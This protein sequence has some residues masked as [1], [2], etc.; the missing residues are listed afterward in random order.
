MTD[1]QLARE[2][3]VRIA[4]EARL[5]VASVVRVLTGTPCAF[6]TT[7]QET[8]IRALA[9]QAVARLAPSRRVRRAD[10]RERGFGAT[11]DALDGGG[12]L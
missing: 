3:L 5:D 8:R 4:R 2:D 10:P 7:E 6:L 9:T 11:L 12:K 1:L